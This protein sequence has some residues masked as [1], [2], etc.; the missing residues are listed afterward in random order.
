MV[1]RTKPAVGSP[2]FAYAEKFVM[3]SIGRFN[4]TDDDLPILGHV[5]QM[6]ADGTEMCVE[7]KLPRAARRGI[8]AYMIQ[9]F[10]EAVYKRFKHVGTVRVYVTV[11]QDVH[12]RCGMPLPPH[13]P[14]W[15]YPAREVLC[16]DYDVLDI[17]VVANIRGVYVTVHGKEAPY[18]VASY[19]AVHSSGIRFPYDAS[20]VEVAMMALDGDVQPPN[21][22]S[23]E[24]GC[25]GAMYKM[26]SAIYR[27]VEAFV[28]TR[29]ERIRDDGGDAPPVL[30]R[31]NNGDG[32]LDNGDGIGAVYAIDYRIRDVL[33]VDE[34]MRTHIPRYSGAR[35]AC[36]RVYVEMGDDVLRRMP[37][38]LP[39]LPSDA[40]L[41]TEMDNA[42]RKACIIAWTNLHIAF[43]C[44]PTELFVIH[45]DRVAPHG[46]VGFR[47][48][49][50]LPEI[51][52]NRP[53]FASTPVNTSGG[54]A[55]ERDVSVASEGVEALSVGGEGGDGSDATSVG[56]SVKGGVG[57]EN[58][59]GNGT[60]GA[61]V[62][63]K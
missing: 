7:F 15:G 54:V 18:T 49:S 58:I 10:G 2:D 48:C 21:D 4:V 56:D 41:L 57:A 42:G 37:N 60:D 52:R 1:P 50:L 27:F 38:D 55:M 3:R 63:G 30:G 53:V 16:L 24:E 43:E 5:Y 23:D 26:N 35:I 22:T 12:D 8:K 51:S 32:V 34:L 47:A 11:T 46:V 6:G 33:E 9:R 40:T 13:V 45:Y 31:V 62:E 28:S 14:E 20:A 44:T 61:T 25:R 36:V 29:V 17:S 59:G 39:Q 19:R